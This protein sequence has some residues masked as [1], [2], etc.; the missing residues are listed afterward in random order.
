MRS[1]SFW[2]SIIETAAFGLMIGAVATFAGAQE[3]T[4]VRVDREFS[5]A[6]DLVG[7]T[8]N[9]V[10][11]Q[12]DGHVIVG[13]SFAAV[14][15]VYR[16]NLA[17][18]RPDGSVDESFLADLHAPA[19]VLCVA[20]QPDG[21]ILA[22]GFDRTPQLPGQILPFV[23]LL[24]DG[25]KDDSFD[26]RSVNLNGAQAIA[27]QADG[28]IVIAAAGSVFPHKRLLRLEADGT[29]DPTFVPAGEFDGEVRQVRVLA[30]GRILVGGG[31]LQVGQVAVPNL[32]LLTA[33]GAL[34]PDWVAR[35]DLGWVSDL[36]VR[37]DG[38]VMATVGNVPYLRCLELT[39]ADADVWQASGSFNAPV[40]AVTLTE[41]GRIVVGG[42]FTQHGARAVSRLMRFEADGR[43]D[44]TFQAAAVLPFISHVLALPD[45]A[46]WASNSGNRGRQIATFTAGGGLSMASRGELWQPGS[47]R[48]VAFLPD[49]RI[50]AVG[51]FDRVNGTATT[52]IVEL[53][54][55]GAL[56]RGWGLGLDG[57]F[58]R[59]FTLPSGKVLAAGGTNS[60]TH[61][62]CVRFRADG[63]IDETYNSLAAGL[64]YVYDAVLL[65]DGRLVVV[66][67][68]S[69]GN[70]RVVRLAAN[71]S[72]DITFRG[73]LV[74]DDQATRIKQQ[75]DGR[76]VVG[77]RFRNVSGRSIKGLVR[78]EADGEIDLTFGET[79]AA[80][81]ELND[82]ALMDDDRI[83]LA[84][85]FSLYQTATEFRPYLH[86]LSA[87]GKAPSDLPVIGGDFYNFALRAFPDGSIWVGGHG[88][89]RSVRPSAESP[90]GDLLTLDRGNALV[91]LIAPSPDG[92]V[93]IGGDQNAA[94][95]G[96]ER[97]QF[98][99][100][101][102]VDRVRAA[103]GILRS[104]VREDGTIT[105]NN[106]VHHDGDVATLRWE[107]FLPKGW[108]LVASDAPAATMVPTFGTTDL[109]VWEWTNP[110]ASPFQFTYDLSAPPFEEHPAE[111][112]LRA[113]IGGV[114]SDGEFRTLAE[115]AELFLP[116]RPLWHAADTNRDFS[117]SL[118]ELLRVIELY[119]TRHGSQ[120][121]GRYAMDTSSFDGFATDTTATGPAVL[122][123]YHTAD[124]NRDGQLSLGELLRVIELYNFRGGSTRIGTYRLNPDSADGFEPGFDGSL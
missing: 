71:G 51:Y 24:P 14:N 112:L 76:F 75:N 60:L 16:R 70:W 90:A 3:P 113:L 2:G 5:A 121:T 72:R 50:L 66:G 41:D 29:V 20:V 1:I 6:F 65:D 120:R 69:S 47:V 38:R 10:A 102:R 35:A 91:Y 4:L 58:N 55:D 62:P 31:F 110:P 40:S 98:V 94:A 32:V 101:Q 48:D 52:R 74:F 45:G 26:A 7:A 78:L 103:H 106:A 81:G 122:G 109:A 77:G 111:G 30:D 82:L 39:G 93:Y 42:S 19:N 8:L 114:G 63:S 59:V 15:G 123:R 64:S 25:T 119:N 117:I 54:S 53:Q 80:V 57:T 67:F 22:G 85:G 116:T 87:D 44:P 95:R 108:V 100:L 27:V 97:L 61:G 18:L 28:R 23:R 37:P 56:E 115:G 104:R 105:V 124:T 88:P 43:I 84:G 99:A 21:K 11:P 92:K 73:D 49:D 79:D 9:A 12:P 96:L 107:V 33:S 89:L 86:V 118:S 83:V 17:R 34:D 36:A 68:D 13:G 46:V